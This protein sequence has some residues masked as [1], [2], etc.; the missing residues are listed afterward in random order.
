MMTPKS[1]LR[2]PLCQSPIEDFLN[3]AK[4]QPVI[5][6]PDADPKLVERLLF[7][8]GKIY[9]DLLAEKIEKKRGDVAIIRIEELY[10]IPIERVTNLSRRYKK[11]RELYWVQEEP[12]N[13]G[14]WPFVN[15]KFSRFDLRVVARRE[16]CSPATG[17]LSLHE[18]EQ[19][20]LIERAFETSS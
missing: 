9:Y 8:S 14:A 5:D 18:F 15:R 20:D 10:P 7:C 6:D 3:G 1:L 19:R 17:Y 13:M 11:A 4:F 2:H 12:A 16:S